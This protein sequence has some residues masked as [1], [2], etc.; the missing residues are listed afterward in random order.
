MTEQKTKTPVMGIYFPSD[1]ATNKGELL[2]NF[3]IDIEKLLE[4][5]KDI[6]YTGKTGKK[7]IRG[8]IAPNRVPDINGNVY[9]AYHNTYTEKEK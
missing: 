8:F 5:N 3:T 2:I 4:G 6:I 7:Y 1:F 9:S